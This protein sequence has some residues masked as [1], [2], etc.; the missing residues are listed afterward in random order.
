MGCA[1][2]TILLRI[3]KAWYQLIMIPSHQLRAVI[4][5]K[6]RIGFLQ[7]PVYYELVTPSH[8]FQ[9]SH[10]AAQKHSRK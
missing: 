8:L 1:T 2:L 10:A 7:S 3:T 9:P 5:Q 4:T 6:F